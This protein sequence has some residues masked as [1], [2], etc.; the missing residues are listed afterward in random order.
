[1]ILIFPEYDGYL[2]SSIFIVHFVKT[3]AL[4]A[5][6]IGIPQPF[7]DV[8]KLFTKEQ[9]YPVVSNYVFYYFSPVFSL[10]LCYFKRNLFKI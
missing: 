9:T 1:V 5:G 10:F 7:S 2:R 4:P 6:L 8:I 3:H